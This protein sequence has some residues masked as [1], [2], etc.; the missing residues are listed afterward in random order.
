MSFVK[1]SEEENIKVILVEPF[2]TGSH[3]RWCKDFQ[4]YSSHSVEIVSLEGRHWKWRMHG[5]AISIAEKLKDKEADLLVVSDMIDLPLLKALLPNRLSNVPI[6]IYMHENQ[7]TYPW[8]PDDTDIEL[9]RDRHYGFINYTSALVADQLLFNSR[10][11]L[12]SFIGAL[13][14]FLSVFPDH[15]NMGSVNEI[16]AKSRVLYLG[17]D[18]QKHQDHKAVANNEHPVILWNHRW[19]YDK[20]PEEFF[21][22]LFKLKEEGLKFGLIV[23]G[24][25][26]SKAP[27]IFKEAK[28]KLAESIIHWGWVESF[29]AYA[30][31]LWSSDIL[32]VTSN[33]DFFGGSVVEAMYCNVTPL[34][35]NRLAYPEH[36]DSEY[37]Y[38]KGEFIT[39]LRKLIAAK[40]QFDGSYLIKYDWSKLIQVYDDLF[41]QL[42]SNDH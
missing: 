2:F 18:L 6:A 9:K 14:D 24:E 36:V 15:K 17:M 11:H 19:E 23:L 5:G 41:A 34:L 28:A 16:S 35:P 3:A 27:V 33:Q 32:P 26:Y 21:D 38:E 1:M 25:S 4:K 20:N 22:V 31:L 39:R 12:E 40:K 13:P 7:L 42:I 30:A 29:E 8:S 10:Y 37:L